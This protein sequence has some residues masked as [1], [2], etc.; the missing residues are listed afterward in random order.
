VRYRSQVA[1]FEISDTGVGIPAGEIERVFEPFERGQGA[2]VRAIPGTGLGLTITKLLTQIMGGEINAASVEG[3]GTTFT[4]R[5]LLSEAAPLAGR[6]AAGSTRTVTGYLGERRRLLL[7]DD[8]AAHLD[9]VQNLLRPLGFELFTAHDGASGLALATGCRPD[10]AMV[11]ISMP[12]MT[13]WQV[14]GQLR[15]L[16]SLPA[17]R[18]AIVSAN[19][20]E[21]SP[22]GGEALH[23]AFLIKPI[24]MQRLLEC[25]AQQLGLQWLHE[26]AAG[27]SAA[28]SID[29]AALPGHSRHHVDDLYQL[30]LIGHV[31]GIQAKL[32]EMENDPGSRPFATRMRALVANFDLKRYMHVLEGIRR[33]G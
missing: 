4:V 19:A 16:A 23:D 7:I 20:H 6:D 21:F 15:A 3:Q 13:G 10:L 17:L 12:G 32:R 9:I 26:S 25:L 30:G 5:L 2:N 24:E 31:R 18:I 14:A 11:D 8:D 28:D 1:E 33:H 29:T 22:G 27:A